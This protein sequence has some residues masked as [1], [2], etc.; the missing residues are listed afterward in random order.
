MLHKRTESGRNCRNVILMCE[1]TCSLEIISSHL[2]G[3]RNIWKVGVRTNLFFERKT[4]TI[5]R[6]NSRNFLRRKSFFI[7]K[8]KLLLEITE[9]YSEITQK[10]ANGGSFSGEIKWTWLIMILTQ[11]MRC[12]GSKKELKSKKWLFSLFFHFTCTGLLRDT[13]PFQFEVGQK[14]KDC[15]KSVFLAPS[16]KI[17]RFSTI[18]SL[19]CCF[20]PA[21]ISQI[22]RSWNLRESSFAGE[23]AW[24]T[25]NQASMRLVRPKTWRFCW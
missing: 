24:K 10:K 20:L 23:K 21:M 11:N 17:Y 5:L 12:W 22:S 7:F 2:K 1:L 18:F 4:E 3:W 25:P 8:L 6:K 9:K 16:P 19:R 13:F 14:L 15:Q